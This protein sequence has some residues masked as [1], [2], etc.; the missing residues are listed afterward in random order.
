MKL[1]RFNPPQPNAKLFTATGLVALIVVLLVFRVTRLR[2]DMQL[3]ISPLGTNVRLTWTNAAVLESAAAVTGAWTTV[4]GATSPY[5]A[6]P[7]DSASFYRLRGS[8]GE[9]DFSQRYVAP[10]F[11]TLVGDPISACGCTSPENPNSL[12]AGGKAQDNG[13]GSV[14]LHTGEL[15]QHAIDLEIPGRGFNWRFER[16][17][18]SGMNYDGPVGQGW[19]FNDNRR[20]AA[21]ANGDVLRVDGLGRVDRYVLS[22]GAYQS[23][24]GFYTRLVRNPDGTFDERDRHG[25]IHSYSPTNG[26][27]IARLT[28][29]RD[30]SGNDMTFAYNLAS[31][32]TNVVDTLGRSIT[33]AYDAAGRLTQVADFTGRRLQLGYDL[34]GNLVSVTAPAVIGTPAGNDFPGG[35]T[36]AYTYSSGYTDPRFDHQLLTVTAPNEV[37]A[38]GP[39]RLS[40]QYDVNSPSTNAGRLLSLRVGGTNAS[41]VSA[42]GALGFNF[43]PLAQALAGDVSTPVFQATVTNRN[44]D[45]AEYQ[46]NQLGSILR[47]RQFTRG[48]RTNEPAFFETQSEYNPDGELVRRLQPEGNSVEYTYDT[49]NPD[50]FQQGNLLQVGRLPG[51]RGG[52]QTNLVTTYTYEPLFNQVRTVSDPRGND[53]TYVPPNGGSN[54]PARY[55]LANFYDY[56][57]SATAP[58]E[59]A[60]WAITIPPALLGLGD[61]NGDGNTNQAR[62]NLILR[63]NSTVNLLPGSNQALAE[64]TMQQKI[65]TR[66]AYNQFGQLTQMEDARGNLHTTAY[67]PENDP[68]GGG[69]DSTPGRDPTTGG[70][71]AQTVSD[72]GL[73]LRRQDPLP[74]VA[75]TNWFAYDRAGNRTGFTDGRGFTTTYAYN[76]LNQLVQEEKPKVNPSQTTG[77]LIRYLYDAN[78]NRVGRDVQNVT[79]DPINHVPVIVPSHPFFQHRYTYDILDQWVEQTVDATRDPAIPASNQPELLTTRYRYDANG[80][81]TQTFSPLAVSGVEPDNY[82]R[83][84]YD[85]RDLRYTVTRGGASAL[86]STFTYDYDRNGNLSRATDAEAQSETTAYDGFD[87]R[88]SVVDRG[89]NEQRSAYDP[90]GNLVRDEF[91]G[92]NGFGSPTNV[93]LRRTLFSQD[94][95]GRQFQVDRALFVGAGVPRQVSAVLQDGPLTPG[96]GYVT[97]RAE[98]D[99]LGRRTFRLEDNGAVCSFTC[100]G[101]GR[102]IRDTLPLTD[103]VTPGGPYPT[104]TAY[105]YDANNNPIRRVDTHTSPSGLVPPT[106]VIRLYVYDA[107][108]RRVRETDA[109]GH[110]DYTEYDSR[111]NTVATYDARGPEIPDPLGLY[112]ASNINARGNATRYA[113]DGRSRR[114]LEVHELTTSGEG[115]APLDTSN[116]YNSDGLIT[117][118]TQDDGNSRVVSRTDDNTNTTAYG[119]DPLNRLISQRNA[120]GGTRTMQYD[121]DDNRIQLVDE[122]DAVHTFTYDGLD[123]LTSHAL[124]PDQSKTIADGT[125]PLIVGTTLQTF[126]YDGLSRL[127]RSTDNN[128]PAD[129]TDDWVVT[130]AYDSLNRLVEEVQ[131]GRPVSSGYVA[132]DRTELHYPNGRRV[133]EFGYDAVHHLIRA[134]NQTSL[135]VTTDWFGDCPPLG[136]DYSV[137]SQAAV[138][139]TLWT[140]NGNLFATNIQSFASGAQVGGIDLE[141][142]RVD[143]VFSI[144]HFISDALLEFRSLNYDSAQRQMGFDYKSVILSTLGTSFAQHNTL[145]LDGAQNVRER[146]DQN[147]NVVE[148]IDYTPVDE[149]IADSLQ[150]PSP[151]TG[152]RT[153]DTNFVY[154][155]DGLNRLRVV[156][157]QANPTNVVARYNYD[158]QPA[159][160]AGRRV[161]KNVTNNGTLDGTTRFYYNGPHCIEETAVTNSIEQVTRQFVFG[162][163]PDEVYAMDVATHGNGVPD[164]LYFLLRDH[165]NN[166]TQLYDTNWIRREFYAYDFRGEPTVYDGATLL[167]VP[168]SPTG[169][170]YLFTG[171]RYDAET[172][173]YYYKARYYDP[174]YG[175]FLSRDPLGFWDDPQNHGNPMACA[176]NNPWNRSD[177]SGLDADDAEG[178]LEKLQEAYEKAKEAKEDTEL[179]GLAI[180]ALEGDEDAKNELINKAGEKGVEK[181][182]AAAGLSSG[183]ATAIQEG[184]TIANAVGEWAA[185]IL[186]DKDCKARCL[187]CTANRGRFENHDQSMLVELGKAGA[188]P[189]ASGTGASKARC[190]A[191][192]R[193]VFAL[194]YEVP[195]ASTW[196]R[197]Y[198]CLPFTSKLCGK[199]K[200][201]ECPD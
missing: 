48:Y 180:K 105:Q 3:E 47:L 112:T 84:T 131:N 165:N 195:H 6:A 129:P 51:P 32:L 92:A 160:Y 28:R 171:Q 44:G 154:Q 139:N 38:S 152:I 155:W 89:G 185:E 173:L 176:G 49:T 142:N 93:L 46:F 86:A 166:T 148:R 1:S 99:A 189:A 184:T 76:A 106:D 140:L 22:N 17:Y 198:H 178:A 100:D 80:N 62:G 182:V 121:R 78:N 43:L 31:Q 144:S 127:V 14:F 177:A 71:P 4:T 133:V 126:Q 19:D 196:V 194:C 132:E 147:T 187:L 13:L 2:A 65:V 199:W 60:T 30:R 85:E 52:D 109:E 137:P 134:A 123:R 55:T 179:I 59:A 50:R 170:P 174:S 68:A 128:D 40:A 159:I 192:N 5:L 102:R 79:T 81:R 111:G 16:R 119:Y 63:A 167:P 21:Q 91:Y 146:R 35:K 186:A 73:G 161:Q 188:E 72:A 70:Y 66:Y 162:S 74:A 118:L 24:S 201:V 54:S 61:L 64:G 163:A 138:L 9:L 42:G 181:L 114:W 90:A 69:Q 18:R 197:L 53:V 157:Q 27:G 130:S 56:Q 87:R 193:K 11:T 110:T 143:D 57:E 149:P 15:T 82:E 37:A 120:D 8:G 145:W 156:R 169:N 153:G 175:V 116:P 200:W 104:Q 29:I 95:L 151:G 23:P 108:N 122:N 7:T 36:T 150:F 113:Y 117:L 20:L 97:E 25:T 164:Q 183:W 45:V 41:G 191:K 10:T 190:K 39:A 34:A 141:R 96:D 33:Y 168:T 12:A 158:A 67:Y 88:L 75:I 26:L 136:F 107:L 94:E 58:T 98:Y 77:Y 103:A 124:S 125:L 83:V 115:G 135:A 172:G 101:A